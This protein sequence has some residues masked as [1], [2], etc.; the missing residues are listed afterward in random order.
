MALG[1]VNKKTRVDNETGLG[2]NS[3]N[4]TER[5]FNKD[6]DPRIKIRGNSILD[7]FSVYQTMLKIKLWK[8]FAVIFTFYLLINLF[9]ASV[10]YLIG[11]EQLGGIDSEDN[12]GKFWEAFFFSAQTLSTVGYGD[13]YPAGTVTGFVASFEALIGWLMFA[14]VT[15]LMYGRFSRPQAYIKFSKNA[16]LAPVGDGIGLMFRLAPF[17]RH[18]LTDVEVKV[19]LGVRTNENGISKNQFFNL[20]LDVARANTLTLNWTL[21]HVI[22]EESPFYGLLKDEIL[23]LQPELLVF[24]K[25]YDDEYSN[26]VIARTSYISEELVFGG[27]FLPMYRPSEDKQHTI[28]D[29]SK[30]NAYE[31][32]HLPALER[33]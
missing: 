4:N 18:Y 7:R 22:N 11:L 3:V 29:L 5:F 30:L 9:F 24:V 12:A 32:L 15:G 17:K 27:R 21:V 10:Y 16:L 23:Q 1:H 28:M 6:G 2:T 20:H 26:M 25:G 19:T 14:V 8:F 13:I 31:K 33:S